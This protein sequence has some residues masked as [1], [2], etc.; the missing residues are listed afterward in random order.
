[1]RQAGEIIA[2]ESCG[3]SVEV[4]PLLKLKTLERIEDPLFSKSP[5]KEWSA[6][7][8]VILLGAVVILV[9][10]A[11]GILLYMTPPVDRFAN[12]TPEQ[13]KENYL[14]LPPWDCWLNW[15]FMKHYGMERHTI[16]PERKFAQEQSQ[17]GVY[18]AMLEGAAGIGLVLI[19]AGGAAVYRNR[20]KRVVSG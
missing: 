19:L 13:V 5:R 16:E 14:Q 10:A 1:L 8:A 15:N 20:G 12:L 4:P 17:Y 6:A 18:W 2:C 3:A 7:K 9:A 11:G